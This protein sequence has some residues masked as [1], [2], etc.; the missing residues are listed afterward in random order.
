[1]DEDLRTMV[2]ASGEGTIQGFNLRGKKAELQSELY[3][4][5]MNCLGMVHRDSKLVCGCGDGRLYMFNWKEFGYHSADFPGHPDA[6]NDLIAA[7]DNVVITG[8]EDGTIR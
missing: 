5:E 6:I 4:G 1:M 7:T 8:C 3:E 2:A